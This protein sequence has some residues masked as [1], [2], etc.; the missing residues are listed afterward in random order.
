[1]APSTSAMRC[2][3]NDLYGLLEVPRNA[4]PEDIR[5]AYRKLALRWHPDKNPDQQEQAAKQFKLICEA[6]Q[7]LGSKAQRIEYDRKYPGP[8]IYGGLLSFTLR[9]A[10]DMFAELFGKSKKPWSKAKTGPVQKRAGSD[11]VATVRQRVTRDPE[12]EGRRKCSLKHE[13]RP[14]PPKKGTTSAPTAC[15]PQQWCKVQ[16]RSRVQGATANNKSSDK[17]PTKPTKRVPCRKAPQRSVSVSYTVA[18]K[19]TSIPSVHAVQGHRSDPGRR[20]PF[21]AEPRVEARFH[22]PTW[23]PEGSPASLP[24][25]PVPGVSSSSS[26][27]MSIR[28]LFASRSS[29]LS[30]LCSI[31]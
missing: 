11:S 14:Q 13:P 2:A 18:H 21:P 23:S 6:Y 22:E 27:F 28:L 26:F 10:E 19:R 30:K 8:S 7:V 9:S 15:K 12:L 20:P 16:Q 17:F 3:S 25:G 31:L 5:Q 1:M 24:H 4:S 29:R